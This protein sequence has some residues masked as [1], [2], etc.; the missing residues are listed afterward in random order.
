MEIHTQPRIA[1]F[2]GSFDPFTIGHQSIVDRGLEIFDR[3]IIGI[4]TNAEKKGWLPVSERRSA[5]ERLY[6]TDS[7]VEVIEFNCLT[8]EA[9]H[10]VGA[11]FLLRGVRSVIDFE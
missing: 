8:T 6:A 5:I 2:A 4:G 11:R 3:I 10:R 7:R 1:L 9:A